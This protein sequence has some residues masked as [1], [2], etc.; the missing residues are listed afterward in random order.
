MISPKE[1]GGKRPAS[2]PENSTELSSR[3]IDLPGSSKMI[4]LAPESMARWM[5]AR[6]TWS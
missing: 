3:S 6:V 4:S 5:W 2:M 1:D